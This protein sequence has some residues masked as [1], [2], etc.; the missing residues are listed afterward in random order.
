MKRKN[1]LVGLIFSMCFIYGFIQTNY[2]MHDMRSVLKS[3]QIFQNLVSIRNKMTRE[4]GNKIKCNNKVGKQCFYLSSAKL[5][6]NNNNSTIINELTSS[7]SNTYLKTNSRTENDLSNGL[8]TNTKCNRFIT[9]GK[10]MG[11]TGNQMFEIGSLLG[12]AYKYDVIPLIPS[13]Y[14]INKYFDLPN[15]V[16]TNSFNLSNEIKCAENKCAVYYNCTQEM[17]TG[18]NITMYGHLQSW[19]YFYEARDVIKTVFK[20]KQEHLLRAKNFLTSV[21]LDGYKR[22]CIHV[23][24]GDMASREKQEEGYAI[25]SPDFIE[26][27]K[28]VYRY[29]YSKVQFIVVSD[30]KAWCKAHIKEANISTLTDPGDELALMCLC[31]DVIVTSGTF[32]W[33]GAWLS[34]GTTVYFN[35]HPRPGSALASKIKKDDLYPPD[36]IGLS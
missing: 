13:D 15:L 5:G 26:K 27:A 24:R 6:P 23:R 36:W 12:T 2:F 16:N 25:A 32:G 18:K 4:S 30:D 14:P 9:I 20:P 28:Q 8:N 10:H 29:K 11:R 3:S 31:D 35:G 34:G 22:V 21:F 33:W 17:N 1:V 7:K 19:K